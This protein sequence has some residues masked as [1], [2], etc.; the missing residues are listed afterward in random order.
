VATHPHLDCIISMDATEPYIRVLSIESL[1][2]AKSRDSNHSSLVTGTHG[3]SSRRVRSAS[4]EGATRRKLVG[5]TAGAFHQSSFGTERRT[6][7]MSL[8][9]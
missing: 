3:P 7:F 1:L 6:T 2:I 4:S 5:Y 9:E 8:P